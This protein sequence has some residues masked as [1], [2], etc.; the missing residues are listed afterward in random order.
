LADFNEEKK[1]IYEA[2]SK[3]GYDSSFVDKIFKK[4][5]LKFIRNQ[6]T[7]L[8]NQNV[9]TNETNSSIKARI[10]V[11]YFPPTTNKLRTIF[12]KHQ[13]Q[14]IPKS[15]RKL[16]SQLPWI[17]DMTAENKKSGI[18]Q[19]SCGTK[20][21]NQKYIGQTARTLNTRFVSHLTAFKN[22]HPDQ[23]SI[24]FHMVKTKNG[25][26]RNPL[27]THTFNINNLKLLEEI[28]DERRLN[29]KET[30]YIRKADQNTLMKTNQGPLSS[31]LLDML[32]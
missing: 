17:K 4:H 23:S 15:D 9:N 32:F 22:N 6:S 13:I 26:N 1:Y 19:I 14:L 24:A 2:A 28:I 11:S 3:N 12:K 25:R 7:T 10:A 18:Y 20:N 8:F 16:N 31:C 5:E 29:P 21:C 30:L 27:H